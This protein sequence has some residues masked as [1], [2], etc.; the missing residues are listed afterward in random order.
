MRR[1]QTVVEWFVPATPPPSPPGLSP[2]TASP[3]LSTVVAVEEVPDKELR[4]H[5]YND[6]PVQRLGH[7]AIAVITIAEPMI[8]FHNLVSLPRAR[9]VIMHTGCEKR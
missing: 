8:R 3:A 7:Q 5:R 2:S 1:E 9:L 6:E 4:R